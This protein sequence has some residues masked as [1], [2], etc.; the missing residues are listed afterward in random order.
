LA[1]KREVPKR[2]EVINVAQGAQPTHGEPKVIRA[3]AEA[4]MLLTER[5][6]GKKNLRP[7]YLNSS[8]YL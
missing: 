8:A 1:S 7:A 3:W 4:A 2:D 6:V 5:E